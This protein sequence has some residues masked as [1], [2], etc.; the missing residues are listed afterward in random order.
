MLDAIVDD[1][2]DIA[3]KDEAVHLLQGC[4]RLARSLQMVMLGVRRAL[5]VCLLPRGLHHARKDGRSAVKKSR[6]IP[7]SGSRGRLE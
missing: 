6:R 5:S 1:R 3:A 4:G 7:R 2:S